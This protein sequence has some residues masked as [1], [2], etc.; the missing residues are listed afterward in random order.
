R[1]SELWDGEAYG[2][3]AP[4]ADQL[5]AAHPLAATVLL[6]S[7]IRFA[8]EHSR[9]KRYRYA[10]E[11]LRRCVALA[12]RIEHWHDLPTHQAFEDE[13]RIHFWRRISFWQEVALVEETLGNTL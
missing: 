10:A 2:L 11:H 1:Q 12:P 6:R 5:E 7:M 9:P 8:L 3:Y 13:L 4:A